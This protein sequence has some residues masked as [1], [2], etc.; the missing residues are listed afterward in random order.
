MKFK[1]QSVA[2]YDFKNSESAKCG[3]SHFK[4][5]GNYNS[6]GVGNLAK[7]VN[8]RQKNNTKKN[9]PAVSL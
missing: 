8:V 3:M 7:L 2:K 1:I 5:V 4:Q 9:P 6:K